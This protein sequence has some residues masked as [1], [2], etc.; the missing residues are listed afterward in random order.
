MKSFIDT[1]TIVIHDDKEME[2]LEDLYRVFGEVGPLDFQMRKF[3]KNRYENGAHLEINGAVFAE[4]DWG[5]AH[6]NNTVCVSIK[7]QGC[8][9]IKDWEYIE[10][11]LLEF[12]KCRISR[13]DLAIDIFDGS[14]KIEDIWRQRDNRELWR[15]GSHGRPPK[16]T[17]IGH[18]EIPDQEGRTLY[19]GSR[20]GDC[21]ARIYEKGLQLFSKVRGA[22]RFSDKREIAMQLEEG[23]HWFKVGDYVRFEVELKAKT[24]VIPIT[25]LTNPDG[26]MA[27][28]YP[29]V[30]KLLGN[31]TPVKRLRVEQL[32]MTDLDAILQQ[33]QKQYGPSLLIAK[34][35][36]GD[37]EFHRRIL[38]LHPSP[39]LNAKG[40]R[41][42]KV[43]DLPRVIDLETGELI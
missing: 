17:P 8:A 5:G 3:G 1:I 16:F 19:V 9:M 36:F 41:T 15:F 24:T 33:I 29:F 20:E 2:W 42:A 12:P 25:A 4:L 34:E 32:A 38:A 30:Q 31:P 27:G 11:Q 18:P 7:G 26:L 14:L 21:M 37:E 13:L 35:K 10:R 39:T 6:Q 23:E 43:A 40:I 22:D 28:T